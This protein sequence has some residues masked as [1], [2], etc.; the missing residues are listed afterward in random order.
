MSNN[1]KSREYQDIHDSNAAMIGQ[2]EKFGNILN[3][4]LKRTRSGKHGSI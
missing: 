3:E 2:L 4:H 1:N